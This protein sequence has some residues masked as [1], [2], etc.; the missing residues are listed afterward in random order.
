MVHI[1]YGLVCRENFIGDEMYCV[2]KKV[3]NHWLTLFF[4]LLSMR[5]TDPSPSNHV[6]QITN[7]IYHKRKQK[8]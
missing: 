4:Y 3:E 6:I 2:V 8:Q 1:I 5:R 7:F